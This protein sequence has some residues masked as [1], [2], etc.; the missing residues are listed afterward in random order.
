MERPMVKAAGVTAG[1]LLIAIGLSAQLG[2]GHLSAAPPQA[3]LASRPTSTSPAP[4]PSPVASPSPLPHIEE[5]SMSAA[6]T[7][8]GSRQA[9]PKK[10]HG[11]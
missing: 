3:G 1:A 9:G 5:V 2:G 11:K 4:S 6:G 10:K 8:Y 7:I